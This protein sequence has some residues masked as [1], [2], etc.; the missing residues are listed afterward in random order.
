MQAA[1]SELET[2]LKDSNDQQ[3]GSLQRLRQDLAATA[4]S[5]KEVRDHTEAAVEELRNLADTADAASTSQFEQIKGQ[6]QV[7]ETDV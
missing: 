6:L 4:G 7:C 3:S 1:V 5:V 2:R